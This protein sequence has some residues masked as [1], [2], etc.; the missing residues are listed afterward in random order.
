MCDAHSDEVAVEEAVR[1]QEAGAATE[2]IAV[3]MGVVQARETLRTALA[4]QHL[5]GMKNSKAIVAIKRIRTR[6]S[7]AWPIPV[8]SAIGSRSHR[9]S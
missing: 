6:R 1:P 5:T 4:I 7:S 3:S 9:N 8:L 2:V